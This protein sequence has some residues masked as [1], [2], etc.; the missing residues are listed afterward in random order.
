V[1]VYPTPVVDDGAISDISY[2]TDPKVHVIIGAPFGDLELDIGKSVPWA[3]LFANDVFITDINVGDPRYWVIDWDKTFPK[4]KTTNINI[5]YFSDPE[6][7]R[8]AQFA[9]AEVAW[10]Y[11]DEDWVI[12]LDGHEALS[13]DTRSLPDNSLA[14]PF[15]AYIHREIARA[16]ALL[17]EQVQIPW[18]AFVR[19][20]TTEFQDYEIAD[21]GLYAT[22]TSSVPYYYQR[23]PL[24]ERALTRLVKVSALRDPGFDWASID[25]LQTASA[26]CKV[27][28]ISYGYARWTDPTTGV[29]E[30]MKMRSFISQVRP[31][32][33]LPTVGTDA[34]GTAG[35]YTIATAGVLETVPGAATATEP[36][37]TPMYSTVFRDNPRDGVW[38]QFGQYGPQQQF[39]LA[40]AGVGTA[41]DATTT[42]T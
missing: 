41:Y 5:D 3:M 40:A 27:Q 12:F 19:Y 2:S 28:V 20:D 34:V 18:Y 32:T 1:D 42:D 33:G 24:S 17:E 7:W 35:P 36:L 10:N 13:C 21:S 23:N 26:D 8:E 39:L 15:R 29:E 11:N 22:F 31:L 14:S 38:Y 16:E 30:G 4:S 37:L 6:G 25:T 9:A